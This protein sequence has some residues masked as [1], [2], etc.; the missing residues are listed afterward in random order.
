MAALLNWFSIFDDLPLNHLLALSL[1]LS[2]HK[3]PRPQEKAQPTFTN[4]HTHQSDFASER[5]NWKKGGKKK[6]G[7]KKGANEFSEIFG[8]FD[9][10]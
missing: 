3:G 7:G 10:Y 2:L 1:S 8:L 9:L 4:D 5:K 6:F